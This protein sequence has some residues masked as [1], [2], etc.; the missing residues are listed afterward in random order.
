VSSGGAGGVAGEG[1]GGALG[2]A[3][4]AG[5]S[6]GGGAGGDGGATGGQAG[7]GGQAGGGG[8][9]VCPAPPPASNAFTA[10]A[11]G[12]TFT[13]ASARL[14]VLV[15]KE[16]VIRVEYTTASSFPA[17]TSL[18][19]SKQWAPV[20]FCVAENAGTVTITT[21]RMKA[22]VNTTSGLV[23]YTDLDDRVVLSE[24]SKSMTAATV[25]G[26][27]TNRIQTIFNSP[28]DEALFG[29]G[30]HQDNVI[31]RKGTNRRILNANTE[32]NIPVLVSNRGYGIFWDNYSASD[33][34]GNESNG[35]KY[36]YSSE[37]G[38][39]VDYYFFYGPSIDQ[40]I[41]GYRVATGGTP[42][43][44]KWAYGL[45]Q[46]KDKY[47]SQ[48]EL[49]N[50]KNG[51]R[52]N[53]IPVDCIV[54]DW[55][56][57]TPYVWGSHFMDEG[58]YPN[59]T[60]LIN[61]MHT[62]N[63]HTMIS[64][65]PLYQSGT[66]R[67]AGELD[68]YNALNGIGALFSTS[69]T[70]H[71]YD[72]FN[73]AARTLVYQQIYDR[74]LGRYGWDGIWADNT[75][76][77]AYPDPVNVRA[78]NTALGKG[79]LYINAYPLGHA[80]G[81]YERWRAV[82]P[83]GKRV[84]VLT[85]SAFAGQ[86]RYA[87][88]C[89]SGDINSDFPTYTRQIPAGLN[90][91]LAGMPYWTTDIGGY[92]GHNVDWTTSANNELFTRWFQYGAFCPIFRIHGGGT[93]ELYSNSWS[94]T[95]KANLLKIDNLRYRLMPYVYSLAWKVTNEGYTMM[96]HLVFDYPTDTN[97]FGIKDQFLFGPAILV[98][99][100]TSAGATS[101]SVYLP[102]GTWYDFWTGATAT[103]GS[104]STVP[105]PLTQIPLF[106]KAGSIV[107]MGPNIQYA[108]E[109]IDPLEIRIYPGR[110]A[111]F[112]LYEDSGDTYDYENGQHSV[113]PFTWNDAARE[114]T[115]G[116][117]AGSYTGMPMTRTFNVVVVGPN[118]GTGVDVTAGPDRMVTYNGSAVTSTVP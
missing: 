8:N 7:S 21:S 104:R 87:S 9:L 54:Q 5:A 4:A 55:D 29:L 115:I 37:A 91:S 68:N 51:Y 59:P 44:P 94:A 23:S 95:T 26:V 74:L 77:Q 45:F 73:D 90:F 65:W 27:S 86:Q 80:K 105:A 32:I 41:A 71:F 110:D 48:T 56:Y 11:T 3:G 33:F 112:A 67:R 102:T 85:R 15:C 53:D 111:S 52:N 19:I 58:R 49:L 40:V 78:A 1:T 42:L 103:G 96:R 14:R 20:S 114:L 72:T 17:K 60:A 18:S 10:D 61:E 34:Y 116:A 97:V 88:T 39:M 46:S 82:G 117:R 63:V 35:T 99:P 107:P 113:I 50:V 101:R 47:A 106:V 109:S 2:G 118:H 108:T 36:R 16:D 79:A 25:E 66:E 84:Y 43:F 76:P 6:A 93:R 81:L 70:H 98:N 57:W 100:V 12:V 64:I 89:W 31:N 75:E 22:K 13:L 92:W 38:E 69:G 28:A 30:Q 62:A 24:D 83:N